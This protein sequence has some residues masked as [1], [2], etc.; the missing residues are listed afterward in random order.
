VAV[1]KVIKQTAQPQNRSALSVTYIITEV[2]TNWAK[3][4]PIQEQKH[5]NTNPNQSR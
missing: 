3:F 4:I 5:K 1:N 2:T